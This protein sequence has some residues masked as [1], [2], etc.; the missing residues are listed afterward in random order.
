[1][2]TKH[3]LLYLVLLSGICFSCKREQTGLPD[4]FSLSSYQTLLVPELRIS[5]DSIRRQV[6]TAFS[7]RKDIS[8]DSLVTDYYRHGKDFLWLSPRGL[9]Q[10]DSLLCRLE[11]SDRHGLDPALF[12][13]ETLRDNWNRLC[14]MSLAE[15]EHINDL[16]AG[17]EAGL[18]KSLIAY[19]RG[20]RYGFIDAHEVMNFLEEE[21]DLQG[22]R[23]P[24]GEGKKKML[25]LHNIP[26][27]RSD[28]AF[29]GDLLRQL[30][31]EK[32]DFWAGLE[33][34]SAYYLSLL[35]EWE[36]L[37]ALGDVAWETIPLIGDTLVKEGTSH[38]ILPLVADR[39]QKTGELS[40]DLP[41]SSYT[42]L[43]PEL[44]QALNRFRVKNL[45]PEDTS[46][47]T[48]TIRYLNRPLQHYKDR[49]RINLERA[50]WQYAE[51]KGSKYVIANVAAY[52]LQAVNEET[53]SILEMR[54]CCGTKRN[55]TPLL[56]SRINYVELNPYWNVP[57]SIIRREM[58]PAYR[59]DS[60]YFR[61]NRL[62]VYDSGGSEVDPHQINWSDY[63]GGV[64][65][66]VK[67][68]NKQG[69][70]LGRIIFRFPNNFAVYLHDTPSKW[71]FMNT[72]RAV[73]HGCVRLEKPLDFA[74]F[75]LKEPD[76]VLEDRIR[77]AMDIAPVSE[78]GKEVV[79]KE[80]Y[81]E[82]KQHNLKE[83]I[84]LFLDYHTVYFSA[85]GELSYAEDPYDYDQ[86]L[87]KALNEL[88]PH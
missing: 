12:H 21:I 47:G 85:V 57:Q 26:L 16:L 45:L 8:Y 84:P 32:T 17:L 10:A 50:R 53:D 69:N 76:E 59:R 66:T 83:H 80:G 14:R 6:L 29:A 38:R 9:V 20:M 62:R 25:E 52:M 64:P 22:R 49:I 54:I 31:E 34:S 28:D 58:I 43:T 41:A 27:K 74:L 7:D 5:A 67:Q 33:P 40:T 56:S 30:A 78:K 73:S 36:G 75:L 88:N 24:L 3:F 87:L 82:L 44:L 61:K 86:P 39:L 4:D 46:V 60:A 72:N 15:G 48:F 18:T 71:A 77:V 51:E 70:S 23:I 19:S 63:R 35:K 42:T 11:N 81:K 13:A 37:N 79:Q 2:N 68:D 1:M 65:F 55:K